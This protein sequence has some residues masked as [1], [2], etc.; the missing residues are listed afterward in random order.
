MFV[1]KEGLA[2]HYNPATTGPCCLANNADCWLAP[3]FRRDGIHVP[4]S[5]LDARRFLN[6]QGKE[7][8]GPDGVHVPV[9]YIEYVRRFLNVQVKETLGPDGVYVPVSYLDLCRVLNVQVKKT[10]GF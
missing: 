10:L 2:R 5:Y 6:V 3:L 8:L 1:T 9:S 7:T 4:V